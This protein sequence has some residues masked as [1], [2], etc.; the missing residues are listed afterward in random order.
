MLNKATHS[1]FDFHKNCIFSS[2]LRNFAA[3]AEEQQQQMEE[4]YINESLNVKDEKTIPDEEPKMKEN[5]KRDISKGGV[6]GSRD[7]G[8]GLNVS[9]SS[10]AMK[11]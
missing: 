8:L 9:L 11:T 7:S 6:I 3:E 4:D 5:K 2:T 1:Q 10:N